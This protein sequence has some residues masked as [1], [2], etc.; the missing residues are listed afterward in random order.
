M[1]IWGTIFFLSLVLNLLDSQND[2]S[3]RL[4]AFV[5]YQL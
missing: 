2:F 1:A 3:V 4:S 5:I